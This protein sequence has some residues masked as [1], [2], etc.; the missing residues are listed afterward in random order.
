MS[1]LAERD[2]APVVVTAT[3]LSARLPKLNRRVDLPLLDQGTSPELVE[4]PEAKRAL[5]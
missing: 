3:F 5:R 1:L 4:R 2:D